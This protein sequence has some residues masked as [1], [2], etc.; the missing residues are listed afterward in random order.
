QV[1]RSND[2]RQWLPVGNAIDARNIGGEQSY[3]T[4]DQDAPA[5]RLY[6]RI[7]QHDVDG[8]SS[9]SAVVTAAAVGESLSI[10]VFPNPASGS[11]RITGVD[12]LNI[13]K[14]ELLDSRGAVAISFS[15]AQAEYDIRSIAAGVY[16]V[17]IHT[18]SGDT[19]NQQL[20]KK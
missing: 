17:R 2:G 9:Y 5:H 18:R 6:Y 19:Q 1:E 4:I 16:H 3:S 8:R 20:I 10:N 13:Q 7:R 14:V 11:F 12:V 15:K